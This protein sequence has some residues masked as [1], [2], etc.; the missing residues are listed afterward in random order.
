MGN[1]STDKQ[2]NSRRN[3][4]KKAM[5]AASGARN[6][7]RVRQERAAFW[8]VVGGLTLVFLIL[9]V[10]SMRQHA[11]PVEQSASGGAAQQDTAATS[12]VDADVQKQ[13]SQL[14]A[15]LQFSKEQ[16]EKTPND[17]RALA[18]LGNAR[19]DLGNIYLFSL[20]DEA[21][22]KKWFTEAIDAYEKA[23]AIDGKDPAVRTDMATAAFYAGQYDKAEEA[24][25]RVIA[26]NPGFAQAYFNYGVFLSHVRNDYQG[27]IANWEKVLALN[28]DPETKAKVQTMIN[29]SRAALGGGK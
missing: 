19:Y 25:K 3:N 10:L 26:E 21:Q 9:L 8:G 18:A 2:S 28:P 13:I 20:G 16:L 22:G 5:P 1:K 7:D 24:Y 4:A 29:Q 14:M 15:S 23:L 11:T 6:N 17:P 27:A 12:Q